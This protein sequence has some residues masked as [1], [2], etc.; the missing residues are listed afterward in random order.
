MDVSNSTGESTDY[1]VTS[2][3]GGAAQATEPRKRPSR[4]DSEVSPQSLDANSYHDDIPVPPGASWLVEFFK[5][6]TRTLLASKSVSKK[7]CLVVLMKTDSG[8]YKV[9][10]CK[11]AAASPGARDNEVTPAPRRNPAGAHLE[12]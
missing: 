10:V 5:P 12:G 3:P 9:Q 8:A 2:R 7:E 11:R 1:R 4:L 6:G